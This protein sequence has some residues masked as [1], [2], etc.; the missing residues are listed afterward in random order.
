[1]LF[2]GGRL[3]VARQRQ[4]ITRKALSERLG[5][6]PRAVTGWE[7]GDYPP[8]EGHVKLLAEVLDFPTSFLFLDDPAG[9]DT[10][11]DSFRSVSKKSA[12]MPDPTVMGAGSNADKEHDALARSKRRESIGAH[13]KLPRD[14]RVFVLV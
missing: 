1:M 4:A 9:T 5:V 8:D 7:A 13:T 3:R 6:S 2:N 12:G 10:S 11:T 14:R